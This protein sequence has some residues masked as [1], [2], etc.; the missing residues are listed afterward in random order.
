MNLKSATIVIT[1]GGRGLGLALAKQCVR[2]GANV[3][4]ADL[5]HDELVKAA[6]DINAFPVICDVTDRSSVAELAAVTE[7]RFGKIDV[8]INNAGIWMPYAPVESI[9][10]DRAEAVMKVNFFGM[11]YG[12]REATIRMKLVKSGTIINIISIRAKQS[13]ALTGAYTASKYACDGLTQ[14]L[15]NELKEFGVNVIGVYPTRIKTQLFDEG[16]KH[17]DNEGMMEPDD[18]AAEIIDNLRLQ[19]PETSLII[20]QDH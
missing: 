1:G 2:H 11:L 8:W 7:K 6:N 5:R 15:R 12:S 19:Q 17:P 9:D 4:I 3:V 18:V 16:Y 14:V 10:L 20:G 13:K